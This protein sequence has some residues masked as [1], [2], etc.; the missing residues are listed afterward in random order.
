MYT[1]HQK[2]KLI[3]R[4][5]SEYKSN[6][7][8]DVEISFLLFVLAKQE[9]FSRHDIVPFLNKVFG[10]KIKTAEAMQKTKQMSESQDFM[11]E[12]IIALE[13]LENDGQHVEKETDAN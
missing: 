5:K 11:E 3:E 6:K 4:L 8:L 9:K 10:S 12:L 13:G 2:E 7:M 1:E